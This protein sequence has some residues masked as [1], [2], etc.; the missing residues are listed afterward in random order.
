MIGFPAATGVLTNSSDGGPTPDERQTQ[1][2]L[3]SSAASPLPLGTDLT[4]LGPADLKL[5][6]GRRALRAG[7]DPTGT[8]R[9]GNL[10]GRQT[11]IPPVDRRPG[12][13]PAPGAYA[14]RAR[15][16]AM[17]VA[18]ISCSEEVKSMR[19]VARDGSAS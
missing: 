17:R 9:A 16:P 12:S 8:R 6:A 1:L 2:S 5:T 4:R 15:V 18:T 10:P 14:L 19:R 3:R 11:T 13:A 7:A